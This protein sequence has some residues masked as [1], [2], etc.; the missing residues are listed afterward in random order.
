MN[1]NLGLT[2]HY[3]IHGN[4]AAQV[5]INDVTC[6]NFEVA[7]VSLNNCGPRCRIED[8]TADGNLQNT[9][10]AELSQ[11]ILL[12]HMV[13]DVPHYDTE[14]ALGEFFPQVDV[15]LR[16]Q[17]VKADVVFRNLQTQLQKFF[18]GDTSSELHDLLNNIG[19]PDGS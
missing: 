9:F 17:T 3:G 13:N 16:G 8:M 19:V 1:C 5:E 18:D 12:N 15:H 6:H 2:S 11:S 14:K 7:C 4:D 10:P